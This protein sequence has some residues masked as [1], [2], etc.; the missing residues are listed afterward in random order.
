VLVTLA[1]ISTDSTRPISANATT[2]GVL[3]DCPVLVSF[4]ECSQDDD[5]VTAPA[6]S[7]S[8]IA[9]R[10][11]PSCAAVAAFV[12]VYSICTWAGVPGLLSAAISPGTTQAPSSCPGD[13]AKPTTVRRGWPGALVTVTVLPSGIP[14]AWAR[15]ISPGRVTHRPAVT[16]MSSSG[17]DRD[18]RPATVSPDSEATAPPGPPPPPEPP[19]SCRPWPGP[20]PGEVPVVPGSPESPGAPLG[21]SVTTDSG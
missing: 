9:A 16:L 18:A 7:A 19:A 15:T 8:V 13:D 6:G 21:S 3:T 1:V 10:S 17:P 5:P 12:K 11:A 4:T 20:F 2:N 14:G